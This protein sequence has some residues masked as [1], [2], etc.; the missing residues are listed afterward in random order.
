MTDMLTQIMM[1]RA[2]AQD[3]VKRINDSGELI[4]ADLFELYEREGWKALG[5]SSWRKCVMAEFPYWSQ[6]YLYNQL[7]AARI[8]QGLLD[9]PDIEPEISTIV[10]SLPESHFRELAALRD[11]LEQR[12]ALQLAYTVG[13]GKITASL[14]RQSVDTIQEMKSTGGKVDLGNGT[15]TAATASVIVKQHEAV[16]AHIDA[17]NVGN[18]AT[19]LTKKARGRVVSASDNGQ[20]IVQFDDLNVANLIKAAW[21]SRGANDLRITIVKEYKDNPT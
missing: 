17:K 1:N 6:P 20:I 11:P 10:E 13:G 8:E 3:R 19:Y 2:E 16:Q 12:A 7:R 21:L 4:R 15:M 9:T 18:V 5:Y 14:V